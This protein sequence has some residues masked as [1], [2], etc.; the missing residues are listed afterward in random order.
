MGRRDYNRNDYGNRRD[1]RRDYRRRDNNRDNY[2]RNKFDRR[3]D[4]GPSVAELLKQREPVA[5]VKKASSS[6]P[7]G[8]AKPR[9]EVLK[10]RTVEVGDN[11]STEKD[12]P[13]ANK[14]K[15]EGQNEIETKE[16]NEENES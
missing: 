15:E 10:E 7:F 6:N 1:D 5:P 4:D 12:L 16:T 3:D 13:L 9:E 8:S 14:T 2:G 11:E